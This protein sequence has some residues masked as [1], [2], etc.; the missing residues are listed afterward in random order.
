MVNRDTGRS[1]GFG[2]VTFADE[3]ALDEAIDRLHGKELDGR[4]ISVTIAKP[5]A[6][7][8][9]GDRDYGSGYRRDGGKGNTS[10]SDCFKCGRP[11]HWA[12]DCSS[13]RSHVSSRD[14]YTGSRS[15][16]YSD[17]EKDRDNHH[18]KSS[19]GRR[20]DRDDYYEYNGDRNSSGD[21]RSSRYIDREARRGSERYSNGSFRDRPGPYD[22]PSRDTGRRSSYDRN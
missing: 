14:R 20:S 5:K 11:G 8:E 1:R 21:G 22:R 10:G 15:D 16:R 7:G 2:F 17:H 3:D 6:E 9:V 4:L 12:R 19:S 13:G 18:G